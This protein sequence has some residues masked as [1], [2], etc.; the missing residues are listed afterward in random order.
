MK[1]AAPSIEQVVREVTERWH[2]PVTWSV[3]GDLDV[4]PGPVMDAAWS[5]IR[6]GVANAAKHA[7]PAE[8]DVRIQASPWAVEVS[9]RDDGTGFRPE[10]AARNVGH[11]GLEMMRRRVAEVQGSLDVRSTPGRGTRVVARL[12]LMDQGAGT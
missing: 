5:V 10:G 7:D 8:V 4:V 1:A 12:P 11:L 3:E 6:E 9:V 2:L